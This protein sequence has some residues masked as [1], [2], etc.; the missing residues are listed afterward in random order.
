MKKYNNKNKIKFQKLKL[1]INY[2]LIKI[3]QNIQLIMDN[4]L[5]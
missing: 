5:K 4:E 2:F 3:N 1:K